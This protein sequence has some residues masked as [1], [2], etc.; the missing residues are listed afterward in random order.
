MCLV[1]VHVLQET[2]PQSLPVSVFQAMRSQTSST[3][4]ELEAFSRRSSG[5]PPTLV[6]SLSTTQSPPTLPPCSLSLSL[7]EHAYCYDPNQPQKHLKNHQLSAIFLGNGHLNR[8]AHA[9]TSLP[10]AMASLYHMAALLSS[11]LTRPPAEV[12]CV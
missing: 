8:P 2:T 6:L 10:T 7:H 11:S 5:M 3:H 12:R 4:L 9:P 1:T